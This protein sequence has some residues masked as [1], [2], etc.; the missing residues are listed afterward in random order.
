MMQF[1]LKAK[2]QNEVRNMLLQI[3][4]RE[5]ILWQMNINMREY[6]E[7]TIQKHQPH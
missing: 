7:K 3:E 5:V 4:F 2:Q 1:G 6:I